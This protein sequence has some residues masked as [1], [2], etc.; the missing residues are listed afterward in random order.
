MGDELLKYDSY[1]RKVKITAKDT[2]ECINGC[3]LLM[4]IQI[5]EIGDY[6]PDYIFYIFSIIVKITSNKKTYND[7]PKVVIQVNEFIV[8]SLDVTEMDDRLITEF[9]EVWFPHDSDEIEFDFQS[10]LASL[11][12]NVGGSRP[13]TTRADFI[14]HPK[15]LVVFIIYQN[16]Q[17]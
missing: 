7:I 3:Y 16:Q 2:E 15:E 13:T 17:Y 11:Y 12:I 8:G 10:S 1:T 6:V 9:Y 4:T 5:N 14:I